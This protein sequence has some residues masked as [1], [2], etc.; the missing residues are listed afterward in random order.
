[1]S[2]KKVTYISSSK[3]RGLILSFPSEKKDVKTKLFKFIKE[4]ERGLL[5]IDEKD[6]KLVESHGDFG[7]SFARI[8]GSKIPKFEKSNVVHGVITAK[9]PVSEEEKEVVIKE[10]AGDFVKNLSKKYERLGELKAIV[11]KDGE[12]KGNAKKEL[13]EEF[14]K[15][16]N[17]LGV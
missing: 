3:D 14:E 2:D 10:A 9:D 16:K 1:M 7:K 11:L 17:E 5:T 4:G 6:Q 8:E 13:V 12:V 15:L